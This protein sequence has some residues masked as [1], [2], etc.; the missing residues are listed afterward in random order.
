MGLSALLYQNLNGRFLFNRNRFLIF[1]L[2][3][4]T[5][6]TFMKLAGIVIC[7]LIVLTGCSTVN[8]VLKS[9]DVDYKYK[10]ACEYYDKKKYGS[11]QQV[12]ESIF[13]FLKGRKEFEDAFYKFAYCYY[14]QSDYFN[15]E[16]LFRQFAEVFPNSPKAVE[17][18]YMRAYTYYRQSPKAELE[19]T[20]THKTIGMMRQFINQHPGTSQAKEAQEIIGKCQQKLENKDLMTAQLYYNMGQ[21]KAASVSYNS[22]LTIYPESDRA[23]MYRFLAIK[24][25]FQYANLSVMDRQEERYEQVVND[26]NDFS[27]KFPESKHLKD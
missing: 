10:K 27:D 11:A 7:F 2:K 24:S 25:Y 3:L 16:N 6:H 14:H 22:M 8:K 20:N 26:C 1:A 23:D 4:L 18:E 9:N 21:Y 13:A 5:L 12:F 17:M 19:Q 15:A